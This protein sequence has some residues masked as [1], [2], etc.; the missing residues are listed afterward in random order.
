MY[1]TSLYT[2]ATEEPVT[3]VE[4]KK[5]V[6]LSTQD[7][8]HDSHLMRL[9][10]AA[11]KYVEDNTGRAIVTQTWE[12]VL[13]MWPS[14]NGAIRFPRAPLQTITHVK[15]Y[16]ENGTQ[17]TWSSANYVVSTNREPGLIRPAYTINYPAF[18]YQP[19]TIS[20]RYVCGYGAASAVPEHLKAAILLLVGH[21][22]D[23]REEVNVGNIT[24][25]V[26][27]AARTLIEQCR[28]GD[29]FVNYSGVA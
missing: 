29:E 17:Q 15:Y 6:E 9:V 21:W 27:M 20:I 23:H 7:T 11:R 16:D 3:L 26:P 12:L 10:S 19:D 5:Q 25:E 28:V 13:D 14:G 22:F 24:T 1:G 18:R 8:A 2:A 4:A